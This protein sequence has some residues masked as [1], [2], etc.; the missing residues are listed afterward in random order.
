[1][2]QNDRVS[3]DINNMN[4][5]I[6]SVLLNVNELKSDYQQLKEDNVSLQNELSK[7]KI[8]LDQ[9]ENNSRR[10]LLMALVGELMN[11]GQLQKKN[12]A[13]SYARL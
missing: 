13:T 1:V 6:D 2:N 10:K 12:C 8:K 7:M 9:Y 4:S 3:F 5:K 11:N